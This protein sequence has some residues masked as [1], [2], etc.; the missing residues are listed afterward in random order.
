MGNCNFVVLMCL[1]QL[2]FHR[3]TRWKELVY[4]TYQAAH[5]GLLP[6]CRG[7]LYKFKGFINSKCE[8]ITLLK[9]KGD[10]CPTLDCLQRFKKEP[11]WSTGKKIT[12]LTTLGF[13]RSTS[14]LLS[15]VCPSWWQG[16]WVWYSGL[17]NCRFSPRNRVFLLIYLQGIWEQSVKCKHYWLLTS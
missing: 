6:L 9:G 4:E 5:G 13:S 8:S 2:I 3:A 10:S 7:I 14:L 11:D 12:S 1:F 17:R 16:L 15:S